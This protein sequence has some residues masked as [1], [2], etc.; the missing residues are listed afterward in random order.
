MIGQPP[1]QLIQHPP[2]YYLA[3]AAVLS[4]YPDWED[5][6]FDRVY[7]VLRLWNALL[8]SAVPLLLWATARRLSLPDPL[9]VAAALVPLA[10][11][12]FTHAAA[13]VNND[14]LLVVLAAALTLLLVR[15]LRGDTRRRTAVAIGALTTLALLTKG[16]A[17]MIP[18][19]VGMAYV[20]AAFRFRRRG[21]L[22]SLVVVAVTA[23]PGLAWWLRNKL[24]YGSL[25][26][27]GYYVQKPD[28]TARYDWSD[29]GA[30]WLSRLI[31]RMITLF[32]VHDQTGER[33]H[34]WP[35]RMAFIAA[36]LVLVGVV[37]VLGLRMLPRT[38]TVI[39][40]APVC[41]LFAIVAMG[42][43]GQFAANHLYAGMQGRYLYAGLVGLGVVAVAATARLPERAR[44]FVPLALL[45]F[46]AAMQASYLNYTLYL[47]WRPSGATGA[48]AWRQAIGGIFN[49]YPLPAGML[50]VVVIATGATAV[51]VV[52]ALGRSAWRST[53]GASEQGLK[54]AVHGYPARTGPAAT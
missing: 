48:E 11:P 5:A 8:T 9:P 17:L 25:Q 23:L 19:W 20:L 22:T 53:D 33:L 10:V 36:A 14:N 50:A 15:V 31:E 35:W 45:G 52:V 28:L 38:D 2:L 18:L 1:N 37:L 44:R 34:T 54:S 29:G 40:L 21:A 47:F 42:S 7:L 24:L 6:P 27:D 30:V 43:W 4:L 13:S 12:E 26:P 16:L 39:L 51:A 49:W 32:F 46:A 41:G 3:G